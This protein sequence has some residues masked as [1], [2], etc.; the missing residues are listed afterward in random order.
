MNID[1]DTI[2]WS[3]LKSQIHQHWT[4]LT[5]ED[6]SS[7]NG[8]TDDFI[9]L[10]RKRYGYGKVQAEIEITRW[11]DDMESHARKDIK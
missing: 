2:K 11:L 4:K 3:E 10:L 5:D 8:R 1:L 7:L 9:A 6:L